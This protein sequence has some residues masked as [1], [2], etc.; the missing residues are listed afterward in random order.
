MKRMIGQPQAKPGRLGLVL[1]TA[2][3]VLL[4]G[5]VHAQTATPPTREELSIGDVPAYR[6]ARKSRLL[7]E[8]DIERGPCP[9]ADP[10]LEGTTV[11][12]ST[13]KFTNL[14]AVDPASL[15]A[16]W[17]GFAGRDMPIASLCEI[18][19]RAATML[20]TMGFLA[21]VQ[22]PPQRI[23]NGGELQLDVLVAR[24]V[25][26]QVRGDAGRSEK[27]IAAHLDKLSGG[28]WFNIHDA[29]RHLLLLSDLP[30]YDV[31]LRLKPAKGAP[32]DVVGDVVVKHRPVELS[33]GTQNLGSTVSGRF[34]AFAQLVIN[35]M[36]GMGDRTAISLFNTVDTEEQTVFQLSHDM[37]LGSDGLRFGGSF[38]YGMGEPGGNASAFETET[39]LVSFELSYPIKR[40]QAQ[41]IHAAGGIDIVN[42][43]I[44]FGDLDLS[45]DKLRVLY[46]RVSLDMTDKASLGGRG[47]Y[48]AAEP[49][50]RVA[51]LV[52]ARQ[53]LDGLG[54][55]KDCS[56][57]SDC[58][59]P[60]VPISNLLADPSAFVL[61][62]EA[63]MEYRPTP[64]VTIGVA[65][66]FQYSDA[67]LLTYEQYSLGNYT[68]GRGFDP[69]VV[70]GDKGAGSTFE[71]RYGKRMPS[72][73]NAIALQPY[74]FF[75][76]AWAWSN[77]D[78]AGGPE[79]VL[80]AG[81]GVRARW[82]NRLDANFVLAAP[83]DRTQMQARK[84]DVR[85]LFTI[86][87]RL[88]PWDPS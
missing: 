4:P 43:S 26:V 10:S 33:A 74:A 45:E 18:R 28:E 27:L 11:N 88:A 61:R 13:V 37:A 78:G 23:E 38:L 48:S 17:T 34:G 53:G 47:G 40:T 72:S 85:M 77:I 36:T 35:G 46:G 20:R 73:A 68:I 63:Q 15:D 8:G 59:A 66:R 16:A 54:S 32:G 14:R 81:G 64:D 29:E 42:Q 51:G 44:D 31:R 3:A 55:S 41:S 69:G 12:F 76:A 56:L 86:R 83:L 58:A 19:D 52:E 70:L 30:G 60:N 62:A 2:G 7:V 49:K 22:I 84:G 65:P 67:I 24:L 25:E 57:L 75:D 80:S 21:A 50:W 82:G 1:A 39:T 79:K 5:A 87:A 71:V 9:L 6:E